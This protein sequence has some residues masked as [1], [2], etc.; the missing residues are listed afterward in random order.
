MTVLRKAVTLIPD[1]WR[2]APSSLAVIAARPT[3]PA[4]VAENGPDR[5]LK[6]DPSEITKKSRLNPRPIR[7]APGRLGYF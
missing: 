1:T 3:G 5:G 7:K 6:R 2:E 4:P